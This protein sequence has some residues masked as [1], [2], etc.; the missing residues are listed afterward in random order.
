MVAALDGNQEVKTRPGLELCRDLGGRESLVRDDDPPLNVSIP[1]EG[2]EGAGVD[3]V[4]CEGLCTDR[5]HLLKVIGVDDRDVTASLDAP[6]VRESG[7]AVDGAGVLLENAVDD[8]M[9]RRLNG[10]LAELIEGLPLHAVLPQQVQQLR[11]AVL[12]D[13]NAR[14]E[15]S[16]EGAVVLC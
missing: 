4:S 12:R 8:E 2:G 14:I 13:V 7:E 6:L 9:M 10:G 15:L 16:D 1:D 5:L 3:A 11:D